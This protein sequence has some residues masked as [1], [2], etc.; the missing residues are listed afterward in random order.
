MT[1]KRLLQARVVEP[2]GR[3]HG[4]VPTVRRVVP[5]QGRGGVR[6]QQGSRR[7][8]RTHIQAHHEAGIEHIARVGESQGLLQKL[9]MRSN[10]VH[11]G[12]QG[13]KS[14]WKP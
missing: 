3:A 8:H 7:S 1:T 10:W 11:V 2:D 5:A 9:K 14:S 13:I 4:R 12:S 6:H